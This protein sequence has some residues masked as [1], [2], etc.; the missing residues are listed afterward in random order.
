MSSANKRTIEQQIHKLAAAG[1]SKQHAMQL[2]GFTSYSF[3]AALELMGPVEWPAKGRSIGARAANNLRRGKFTQAQAEAQAMAA[4]AKRAKYIKTVRGVSGNIEELIK[5]FGL[6]I[7][8]ATVRRRIADGQDIE[9][10]LFTPPSTKSNLGHL[11]HAR[12]MSDAAWNARQT[13]SSDRRALPRKG[14]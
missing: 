9:A 10:A 1:H 2:L 13:I 3:E 8:A 6:K 7:H 14:N 4:S 12:S 11:L 5:A